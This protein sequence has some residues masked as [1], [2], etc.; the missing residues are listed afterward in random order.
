MVAPDAWSFTTRDPTTD[1][2]VLFTIVRHGT[3][4]FAVML[5]CARLSAK[6][7]RVSGSRM[8]ETDDLIPGKGFEI[9]PPPSYKS[10]L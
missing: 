9:Y 8:V 7:F 5:D 2:F 3:T 1:Q 6:D 10:K 4:P